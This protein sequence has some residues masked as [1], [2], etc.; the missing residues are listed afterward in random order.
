MMIISKL[1]FSNAKEKCSIEHLFII[2]YVNFFVDLY[3]LIL[4]SFLV[5]AYPMVTSRLPFNKG[6]A[7]KLENGTDTWRL[8]AYVLIGVL[9]ALV[10][11]VVVSLFVSW[12]CIRKKKAAINR[13]YG[14]V[15]ACIKHHF[16]INHNTRS[17]LL[18]FNAQVQDLDCKF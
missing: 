6:A 14:K 8:L 1:E 9:S 12:H 15:F 5:D 2:S 13:N 10:L 17:F 11:T 18:F 3:K 16:N 4:Q 7:L